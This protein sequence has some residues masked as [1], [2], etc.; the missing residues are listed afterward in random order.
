ESVAEF[1]PRRFADFGGVRGVAWNR[2]ADPDEVTDVILQAG[3]LVSRL[4]GVG[5]VWEEREPDAG[6][7]YTP[8]N[9]AQPHRAVSVLSNLARGHALLHGRTQLGQDDLSLI[10]H[11]AL[12]SAPTERTRLFR[13]LADQQGT[14]TTRTAADVLAVSR[15]TAAKA[16]KAM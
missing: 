6:F 4:R 9:I 11:V 8:G 16:M 13:A 5:S 2:E 7:S 1:L 10:A 14:V 15:P 12:S 3:R